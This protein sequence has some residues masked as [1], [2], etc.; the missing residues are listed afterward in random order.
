MK[1]EHR[2]VLTILKRILT[3]SNDIIVRFEPQYLSYWLNSYTQK[4]DYTGRNKITIEYT[5]K[6]KRSKHD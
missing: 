2:K 3:N 4:M 1:R 5:E 6:V